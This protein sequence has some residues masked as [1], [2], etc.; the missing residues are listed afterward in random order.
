M[1]LLAK[2]YF[3]SYDS[4]LERNNAIYDV[5]FLLIYLILYILQL[6]ATIL[7]TYLVAIMYLFFFLR[8]YQFS[9]TIFKVFL[10]ATLFYIPS[11]ITL[12]HG[13]TPIFHIIFTPVILYLAEYLSKKKISDLFQIF[14]AFQYQ[15][16]LI[17]T[18]GLIYHYDKIDPI[19]SIIPW[20][21]RNG[22]TSVLILCH[23]LFSFI[24]FRHKKKFPI[25]S[26][27]LVVI[28]CFYALGRGSIITSIL[29][30]LLGIT[31]NVYNSNSKI[32]KYGI[33]GL[34]VI[35]IFHFS[36]NYDMN[37]EFDSIDESLKT[38]QFGQGYTDQARTEI[39]SE[40]ISNLSFW[41]ILI[42]NSYEGTLI[43]KYYGGNPHNS[44]LRLHSFYGIFG[45]IT[46]F[47]ILIFILFRKK[48]SSDKFVFIC[49]LILIFFRAYTEPILF[50]SS[51]DLFF[52]LSLFIYIKPR[53]QIEKVYL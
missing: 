8:N 42:G 39:N 31:F 30:L 34:F 49:L 32:L 37:T 17:V 45:L 20:V 9:K 33:L 1:K 3:L 12:N 53:V 14:R 18:I 44:F 28:I 52:F 51:L 40:Y 27:F 41:K 5:L 10:I 50:P 26:T 46:V 23:I 2:L 6:K 21:S 11:L 7:L 29:L 22:I 43:N 38:T 19:G 13:F 48:M 36:S 15:N 24:A 35:L 16:I 4:K 25:V 47:L